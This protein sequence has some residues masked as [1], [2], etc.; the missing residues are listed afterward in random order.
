MILK[1]PV[2]ARIRV[3]PLIR[4]K[5]RSIAM[6][7][8]DCKTMYQAEAVFCTLCGR[9]LTDPQPDVRKKQRRVYFTTLLFVPILVFAAIIGHYKFSLPNGV[10]AVVNGDEIRESELDSAANRRKGS[11]DADPAYVRHETLND[12]ITE[13]LVLQ[14][15]RKAGI[16]VSREEITAADAA[17]QATSGLD[18]D[19]YKEVVLSVYG[20]MPSYE[21]ELERS[22]MIT[23]LI[24]K[25]IVPPD[26]DPVTARRIVNRWL[27]G[28]W[29]KASVR[30]ALQEELS[31]PECDKGKKTCEHALEQSAP[32]TGAGK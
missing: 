14:E 16:R 32:A 23:R 2:F 12:L 22:L 17:S 24:T 3:G 13:R 21:S 4:F 25:K 7:C 20:S 5:L 9:P 19:A 6:K 1:L 28:L 18:G 8:P 27:Q 31:G 10:A 30:I 26:S 29:E 15:A 11:P